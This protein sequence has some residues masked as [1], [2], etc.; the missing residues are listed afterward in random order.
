MV[1]MMVVAV[2][3][4]DRKKVR[5]KE[6]ALQGENCYNKLVTVLQ[7]FFSLKSW[8]W[9]EHETKIIFEELLQASF[10][11]REKKKLEEVKKVMCGG[12]CRTGIVW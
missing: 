4:N 9:K 11:N 1:K 6:R 10:R 7:L 8:K 5:H 12:C 3:K 2:Y